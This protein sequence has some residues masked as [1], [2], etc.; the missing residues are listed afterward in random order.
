MSDVSKRFEQVVVATH[1]KFIDEGRLYPVKTD[2]G[3]LVGDILISSDGPYKTVSRN[4]DILYDNICLNATAIKI[5]N[6]L[7]LGK[8]NIDCQ[9]IYR[10][11]QEYNKCYV[12]S[13]YTLAGY[14]ACLENYDYFKADVLWAR[15]CEI[16]E[17]ARVAK[18]KAERLSSF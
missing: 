16:K 9:R 17:Q 10:A 8:S 12:D 5:A 6:Y 15:Y 13:A 2:Q 1:K 7:A 4:D 14:H 18:K 3:I 11:D